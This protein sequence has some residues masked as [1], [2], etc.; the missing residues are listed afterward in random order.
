MS[1]FFN[2][3]V[4]DWGEVTYLPTTAGYVL[5][6]VILAALLVCAAALAAKARKHSPKTRTPMNARQLAFCAICIALATVASNIKIFHFPFGGSVTLFS[7]LLICL[8]GYF[9]GVGTGILAAVGYGVLQMI[10]DPYILYPTQAIVDYILAFGA[11]GLSGLFCNA[12]NGLIKGFLI[13]IAG[14]WVFA[15]I[16]GWIFFGMYAWEGWNPIAYS[17]VYNFIYIAAEGAVTIIILFIPAVKKALVRAKLAA[18]G[19]SV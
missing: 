9:Y 4:N 5:L 19:A 8:P 2:S 11:L 12:K 14:R 7:M 6:A 13:G 3:T 10:I 15:F 1:A 16:S 18:G 17:A